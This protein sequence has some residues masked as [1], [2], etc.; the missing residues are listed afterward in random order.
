MASPA[1]PV[2][3]FESVRVD[4]DKCVNCHSCIDACPVKF[5]NDGS[6]D[7][8]AINSDLCI[9][10]GNCFAACTHD[11][12]YF[13]DDFQAF[14]EAAAGGEKI[15]A[16]VSPAAAANFPGQ[17]LNLN[18][19]LKSL[20][21]AAVFDVSFGAELATKSYAEHIRRNKPEFVI[22]Q[23]CAALVT[24]IQIYHPALLRH[25]A[26]VHSPMMHTVKM[27]RRFHP[28][29]AEHRIAVVSP[30]MAKK[31]EFEETGLGDFNIG[32][33]SIDRHLKALDASLADFPTAEY[34]N[35][36]AER[37]VTFSAPGGLL[38]TLER[39]IPGV[40]ESTRKIEG[41]PGVYEYLKQLPGVIS[42][43]RGLTPLLLD[44]LSCEKGC[45]GGPLSLLKD[46]SVDEIESWIRRRGAEMRTLYETDHADGGAGQAA[47]NDIVNSFWEEG[48]YARQ[49]R[50]LSHNNA[51]RIPDAETRVEIFRS[52]HKYGAKD[53]FDCSACGYHRCEQMAV[54]IY[55]G[56]NRPENC[57]HYL[58]TERE[59][60]RAQIEAS[61]KLLRTIL[62][63][64][65]QGFC[66]VDAH[67]IVVDTNPRMLEFFGRPK[68]EVIGNSIYDFVGEES[69]AEMRSN[70]RLRKQRRS[71]VYEVALVRPDESMVDCLFYGTPLFDDAGAYAGSF[72][73]VSDITERKKAE[74][75][76]EQSRL[77][78]EKRV[79]E[80]TQA[81]A[82]S[83]RQLHVEI[84]ERRNAEEEMRVAKELA[85]QATRA[86]SEFLANM[87]HEIRT[88]MNGV[89]GMTGLLLDTPLSAEQVQYA[90]C[91]R[92]S[93]ESLL[94]LINDILD[95]SKIESG[96]FT[97]E[98]IDFDLRIAMEEVADIVAM[99]AG[100]KGLEFAVLVEPEVPSLLRGDPG[101]LRQILINLT[102][103][104]IKFTDKGEVAVRITV[105]EENENEVRLRFDVTDTGI[106][107]PKD[108]IGLLFEAFVQVDGSTT[109]RYGGTG[110]GLSISKQLVKLMGGE[111]GVESE[112]G[113]GSNFWFTVVLPKQDVNS[114]AQTPVLSDIANKRV[115]V[116]DD[117][118]TNRLVCTQ[119]LRG[120]G[121]RSSEAASGTQALGMLR[122]AIA[123]NDPFDIAILDMMMPEMDGATLGRHIKADPDLRS[124]SLV[125]FSSV[126]QR[127][128]GAHFKEIGFSAYLTKP[129]KSGHLH[130]CLAMIVGSATAPQPAQPIITRHMIEE[131]KARKL[132]VLVAEDNV[133]NQLVAMKILEKIGIRADCVAN[134]Q[135]VLNQLNTTQYD[136]ILMDCQMPEM[137]GFDATAA[138][139]RKEKDTRHTTII[140]MTANAMKGDKEECIAAGMDDYI[141]KP[142]NP[143]EL[144]AAIELWTKRIRATEKGSRESAGVP[145]DQTN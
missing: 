27:I 74:A 69:F 125:M 14:L 44:C 111:I 97:I 75:E 11:A 103:N 35:P 33:I 20:G 2:H 64:T 21:V 32:Y 4:K 60:A 58:T 1:T 145:S 131:G 117:N 85:E 73:L 31:R 51:I 8:I 19:W 26:P 52:M 6:G 121:V 65:E 134:G 5:C 78:L 53:I 99:R 84:E 71:T 137:D 68:G 127:G 110:L 119:L 96:R 36:P 101:R 136:I 43:G 29:Y 89:I 24:Y 141:A 57:H 87:S 139:R 135:E 50:N 62:D 30:C 124:T 13:V 40:G 130:D 47:A 23:P 120:W 70:F 42:Q 116:V 76:L 108:R 15:V 92:S 66:Q 95:F 9:A 109:R 132:R 46:Q 113:K 107:I 98:V 77:L 48:L 37:A 56:L 104:A 105:G 115:L 41:I 126:G 102:G 88:P 143:K 49:Y 82:Q 34:D 123:A 94:S 63:T 142:I 118:S 25:L 38:K 28:Q 7:H 91:A 106:G 83:N 18:G 55:N 114:V 80:R 90:E 129:V 17:Y 79:E 133:V 22:A 12:R 86:K 67:G 16:I 140:A 39:W 72:A 112:P 122:E 10:C 81:L 3:L 45:N 93:G 54:A 144:S 61:E 128:D 100:Q 59:S 138:I